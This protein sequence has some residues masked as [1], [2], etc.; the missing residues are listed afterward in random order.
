MSS[1]AGKV[2]KR[3]RFIVEF[4]GDLFADPQ[5]AAEVSAAVEAGAGP[6]RRRPPLRVQGA[7]FHSRR[8]RSRSRVGILLRTAPRPQGGRSTRQRDMA[9]SMDSLTTP[10]LPAPA[11][12]REA[13][14]AMPVQ[15]LRQFG[16]DE[17][18]AWAAAQLARTPWPARL[19]IFGG[20]FALTFYGAREMYGVVEV[21]VVTPLE[22][23]LVVLFVVDVLLDR[24][25]LHLEPGRLRLARRLGAARGAAAPA[26]GGEDGGRH[27]DLQR[28]A[29]AGLLG[30][31][32]DLRRRRGDR[33]RRRLR[34]FLPLRHHRSRHLDRRGARAAGD[35]RAPARRA[36]SI[37][38]AVART[39]P[40]RPATSP[41]SSRAGAPPIRRW[42]C[43]TPTA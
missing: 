36:R 39:S 23:A 29:L 15:S 4:V 12:P 43:S 11:T 3:R 38:G 31:A 28:G 16:R 17:R 37:T 41:T 25:R 18:R 7:A 19:F 30:D 2:G 32:G 27:A 9:L 10:I 8:L 34:L 35:A 40:A 33:A 14:L 13:P 42:W 1:R 20:A 24:P 22:W 26:P 6:D 21:G 5:K